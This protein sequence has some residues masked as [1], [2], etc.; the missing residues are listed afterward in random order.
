[1]E[2]VYPI[3]FDFDDKVKWISTKPELSYIPIYF[4]MQANLVSLAEV[5]FFIK[6]NLGYALFFSN[7]EEMVLKKNTEL[8]SL[9]ITE[10][11]VV[12]IMLWG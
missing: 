7:T 11:K 6:G 2:Y 4:T 12:C 1:M 10:K 9:S 3:R 5:A 8:D